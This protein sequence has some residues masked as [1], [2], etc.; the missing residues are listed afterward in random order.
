M[1]NIP[2]AMKHM[3][4]VQGRITRTSGSATRLYAVLQD[5]TVCMAEKPRRPAQGGRDGWSLA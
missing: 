1:A 5:G 3:K 2:E 4:V